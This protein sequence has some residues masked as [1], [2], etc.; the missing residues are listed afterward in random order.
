[1]TPLITHCHL[2]R[3]PL[4]CTPLRSRLDPRWGYCDDECRDTAEPPCARHRECGNVASPGD[5]Y[6]GDACRAALRREAAD[7]RAYDEWRDMQFE[8]V[9]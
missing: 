3:V 5:A 4:D 2:C 9:A 6:C 1:M 8:E 7:D